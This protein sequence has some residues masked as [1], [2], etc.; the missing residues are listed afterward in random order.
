[1]DVSDGL[2]AICAS[3]AR[4]AAWERRW[5]WTRCR[6]PRR[7][8]PGFRRKSART[9]RCTA[10]TTTSFSLR[11]RPTVLCQANP[12]PGQ[13]GRETDVHRPHHRRRRCALHAGRCRS[14]H[15]R[16]GLR[17]LPLIRSAPSRR[18]PRG[19]ARWVTERAALAAL[20]S[21][22][23]QPESRPQP[24]NACPQRHVTQQ[25]ALAETGPS[26]C[27]PCPRR[28]PSASASITWCTR[29]RGQYRHGLP[30]ARS[31]LRARRGD[32]V[33]PRH[34]L[35]RRRIAQRAP[36]VPRRSAHVGKL[37]HP[38]IVPIY[39]AGEE[40]G[41]RY[42]V[43]S[44]STAARTLSAYCRPGGMLP[45][46]QVGR[47]RLQVR[48]RRCTTR[49]SRGVV[50]RDIK[51]SNILLTHDGDVRIVD[52]GIALVSDSGRVTAGRRGRQPGLHVPGAG[53]GTPTSTGAPT[54]TRW[55]SHVRDALRAPAVPVPGHSASCCARWSRQR[56]SRCG[57]FGP[58]CRR[59][60]R[61][62]CIGHSRRIQAGATA[63][64][65]NSPRT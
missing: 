31:V 42:V 57:T 64:A 7:C 58:R 52:F 23:E 33:L 14:G 49:N 30:V 9:S 54:S 34:Q 12:N 38:N 5:S 10:A 41:R 56:P 27:S 61:R 24:T 32:Q 3:C 51:P 63:V 2:L 59:N 46:D 26:R 8:G 45:I 29:S 25:N 43:R 37:Q 4:P 13:A 55:R 50:H 15:F 35:R 17:P 36:H 1:M 19:S 21:V 40:D 60:S 62:S 53:A 48:K 28:C 18:L 39:D 47:Y 16:R 22:A 20:C 44:T 6:C 65:R 11:C